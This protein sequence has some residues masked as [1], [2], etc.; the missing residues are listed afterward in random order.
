MYLGVRNKYC[1]VCNKAAGGTPPHHNCFRNWNESSSA[2]ETDIILKGFLNSEQKHGLRYIE[3]IGD[4]DSLVFPVLVSG[5]PYGHYIKKLE[6]ANYA[7]KC[8]RTALQHLINDKPSYKGRGKLTET[9]Q[10]K[11]TKAARS[12]I[13]MRSQETDKVQVVKKLQHDLLNSQLHSFGIHSKC[14]P[15]YCKARQQQEQQQVQQPQQQQ[16]QQIQLQQQIHQ[17]QIQQ[18]QQ[19]IQQQQI[20]Q[21]QIQQQQQQQ[22]NKVSVGETTLASNTEEDTTDTTLSK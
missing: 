22:S 2:M 9:M 14:S 18:Q 10:K 7:V 5:V 11:L 17:Q 21:Q 1:S 16:Q 3:F 20:Q 12:A 6:C 19:Q 13:I 4:G 15:D 8:Y